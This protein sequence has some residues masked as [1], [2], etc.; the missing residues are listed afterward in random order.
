M[1]CERCFPAVG[2]SVSIWCFISQWW[3][4]CRAAILIVSGVSLQWVAVLFLYGVLYLSGGPV[5]GQ[6]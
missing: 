3:A 6:P 5:V 2:C 1:S 4:C